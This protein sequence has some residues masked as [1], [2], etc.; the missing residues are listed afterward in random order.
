MLD[1]KVERPILPDCD[2]E[3]NLETSPMHM[4]QRFNLE[5]IIRAPELFSVRQIAVSLDVIA[6][7]RPA[8][9]FLKKLLLRYVHKEL[10]KPQL[11]GDKK[12]LEKVREMVCERRCRRSLEN[13]E[14][15][16]PYDHL[17]DVL[18]EE[19]QIC[20]CCPLVK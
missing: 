10:S 14:A 18:R 4:E 5:L 8:Q 19:A 12:I 9:W 17:F 16:A 7:T 2:T 20:C 11:Q 6:T 13:H 1:A 3:W 15:C